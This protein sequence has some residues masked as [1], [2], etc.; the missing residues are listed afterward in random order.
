[1]LSRHSSVPVAAYA[2]PISIVGS[3]VLIMSVIGVVQHRKLKRERV[4]VAETLAAASS[5]KAERRGDIEKSFLD[6]A[7]RVFKT[8]ANDGAANEDLYTRMPECGRRRGPWAMRRSPGLPK[9]PNVDSANIPDEQDGSYAPRDGSL[10]CYMCL[11]GDFRSKCPSYRSVPQPT[12]PGV[13]RASPY[14]QSLH[15]ETHRLAR[16]PSLCSSLGRLSIPTMVGSL[17][18]SS[19]LP[20][21]LY[22]GYQSPAHDR[23]S[24]SASVIESYLSTEPDLSKSPRLPMPAF[25]HPMTLTPSSSIKSRTNGGSAERT[26]VPETRSEAPLPLWPGEDLYERVRR[27]VGS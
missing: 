20:I 8:H 7:I 15:S 10:P 11:Y 6:N 9:R 12:Q 1:M 19:V 3:I 13:A 17:S 14:R 18:T 27:A 26:R 2:I 21:P 16:L 23:Q 25:E 24:A 5:S 22:H 4:T